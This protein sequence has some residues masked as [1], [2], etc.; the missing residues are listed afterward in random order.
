MLV[1]SLGG[2]VR[3]MM[4]GGRQWL[5]HNPDVPFAP[6]REG[7]PYAELEEAGGFDECFPTVGSCR[8]PSWVKGAGRVKLPDHGELWAQP[9]EIAIVT[10]QEGHSATCTWSG[11]ALPYR[12]TRRITVHPEGWV[13]FAYSVTNTG[14]HR[15][16]FLWSSHPVFPL[17]P[18][19]RLFLPEGARTRLW[20]QRGVDF[21]KPGSEHQ[22]PRLRIGGKLVDLSR[23]FNAL[24]GDY[25]CKLFVE[26]PRRE[27]LVAVEEGGSRLEMLLH[28]R[29]IPTVGVS[30]NRRGAARSG[31]RR[32]LWPFRRKARA[33]CTVSIE[34]CL[35]APERLSDALGQWDDAHWLEPGGTARWGMT[36]RGGAKPEAGS[37]KPEDQ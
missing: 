2:K 7:A 26:L 30:I 10:D 22:W 28:G 12:F 36:W 17:T 14:E 13:A 9:P 27:V 19:T 15:I 34:P 35:G 3:D 31:S 23:P 8:L 29:E 20:S 16:P 5:W 4:L 33:A 37:G 32:G 18:R 1:P 24:G 6:P 25:A 21:G 11:A